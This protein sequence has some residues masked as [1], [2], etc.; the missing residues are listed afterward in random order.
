MSLDRDM[1]KHLETVLPAAIWNSGTR[2][3]ADDISAIRAM[4]AQGIGIGLLP[5][6][7]VEKRPDEKNIER[8]LPD[9]PPIPISTYLI[10]PPQRF[11]APKLRAFLEIA[12]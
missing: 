11:L 6:F 8:I 4:V 7:T 10:Y 9:L 1:T 12:V 5:S 3:S 2:I